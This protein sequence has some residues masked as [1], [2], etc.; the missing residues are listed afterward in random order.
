[1]PD[2][3]APGAG[4][5]G[6]AVLAARAVCRLLVDLLAARGRIGRASFAAGEAVIER[7]VDDDSISVFDL[8]PDFWKD[9]DAVTEQDVGTGPR[10]R[11]VFLSSGREDAETEHGEIEVSASTT[12]DVDLRS[13]T[14]LSAAREDVDTGEVFSSAAGEG[15]GIGD[16]ATGEDTD[17]GSKKE[18]VFFS[19]AGGDELGVVA[20]SSSATGKE[21]GTEPAIGSAIGS[22]IEDVVNS[23]PKVGARKV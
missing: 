23:G 18:G 8:L 20:L 2:V 3:L 12:R 5:E 6:R 22:F 17:T 19:T 11:E 1:M 10:T 15:S 21:V 7:P 9:P 16:S 4:T 13:G 14:G